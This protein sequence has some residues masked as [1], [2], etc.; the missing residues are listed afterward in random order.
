MSTETTRDA[1]LGLP[2]LHLGAVTRYAGILHPGPAT[3]QILQDETRPLE[4]AD[5]ALTALVDRL[6]PAAW[7]TKER[8]N[9]AT[10]EILGAK[11]RR[12]LEPT[13]PHGEALGPCWACDE[14]CH[15]YVAK[16]QD[17]D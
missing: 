4:L 8:P 15:H 14:T 3:A 10:L 7:P 13:C 1:L 2:D 12:V 5:E 6:A 11:M 17:A 16:E 9:A